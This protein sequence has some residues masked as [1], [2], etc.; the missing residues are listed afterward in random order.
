M[1]ILPAAF[2]TVLILSAWKLVFALLD[3]RRSTDLPP[4]PP[5]VPILGNLLIF[6]KKWPHYQFTTWGTS[7]SLLKIISLTDSL[8]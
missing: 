5:T 2:I 3:G 7:M 4:G 1:S 8:S 6:P